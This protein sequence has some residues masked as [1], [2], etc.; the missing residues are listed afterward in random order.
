MC[1]SANS[2][3]LFYFSSTEK[4][5]EQRPNPKTKAWLSPFCGRKVLVVYFYPKYLEYRNRYCNFGPDLSSVLAR[6]KIYATS[7]QTYSK[8]LVMNIFRDFEFWRVCWWVPNDAKLR[9]WYGC[10]NVNWQKMLIGLL[11]VFI[12]GAARAPGLRPSCLRPW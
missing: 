7:S 11:Y 10:S 12:P 4:S 1:C 5:A 3:V 9:F 6:S 8:I 2:L